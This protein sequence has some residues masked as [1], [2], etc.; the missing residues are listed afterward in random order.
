M[1]DRPLWPVGQ[2]LTSKRLGN[3][4][5]VVGLANGT[6]EGFQ[7]LLGHLSNVDK[8]ISRGKKVLLVSP[9]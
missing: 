8:I 4:L 3:N 7:K 6:G 1:L 9:G 2:G 5:K